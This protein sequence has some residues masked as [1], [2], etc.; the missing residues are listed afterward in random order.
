MLGNDGERFPLSLERARELGLPGLEIESDPNAEGFYH[1][2]RA[3]RVGADIAELD[4]KCVGCPC[5][6]TTS[7]APHLEVSRLPYNNAMRL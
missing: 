2:L 3:R 4:G 1:R 5:L 7:T 6:C